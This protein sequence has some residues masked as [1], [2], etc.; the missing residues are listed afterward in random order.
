MTRTITTGIDIGTSAV[1]VIVSEHTPGGALPIVLGAGY[2][3]S[4]GL[5]NGYIMSVS[6]VARS[7]KRALIE[8]QKIS[9]VRIKKVVLS[10][11]GIGL[12]GINGS[13]MAM[14]SRAD[15]EI[16]ELD[17]QKAIAA[18]EEG[19]NMLNKKILHTIPLR[20]KLDGKEILGRPSGMRG[21]KLEVKTLFIV[22]QEQHL[23]DL[24][25]AVEE[26]GVMVDDVIASPIAASV[27]TMGRQQ[28]NAGCV[29]AD[30]GAETVAI[31]TFENS[32]P[33]SLRIFPIGSTEIT[34]DIALGF[35]ITLE[36]ADEIKLGRNTA[37]VPRGRV[38]EIVREVLFDIF[39]L[40]ETHLKKIGRNGL[41]PAGIIL[42]GGG[43]AIHGI[44]EIARQSL[45]L[46]ARVVIPSFSIR[47]KKGEK[48]W[49]PSR[50]FDAS[51]TTALGL[52][53]AGK[54]RIGEYAADKPWDRLKTQLLSFIKKYL[55]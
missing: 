49:S 4:R 43:S 45:R 1:R 21:V 22:C 44:E 23:S 3:E 9:G 26:A 8:A 41:L 5:K 33:T 14:V 35:K 34:H 31:A 36:E 50:P 38:E 12:E 55:P 13:G 18:S 7:I 30:I 32:I 27:A 52:C 20:F 46:P 40:I 19:V 54:E 42:T 10:V 25:S 6:D 11:G 47:Q 39:E 51:W 37:N 24:I 17:V 53:M 29:L 16:T 2:A 28:K 48:A 15:G